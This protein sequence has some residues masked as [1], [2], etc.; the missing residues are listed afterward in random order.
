MDRNTRGAKDK[1]LQQN[2]SG[3]GEG[4]GVGQEGKEATVTETNFIIQ[5]I[6]KQGNLARRSDNKSEQRGR[7]FHQDHTTVHQEYKEIAGEWTKL[8]RG[9]V[10]ICKGT[11]QTS[12]LHD[13]LLV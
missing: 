3:A 1:R 6:K 2:R 9:N 13:H 7:I 8:S 12:E 4:R 11:E 5:R 10:P